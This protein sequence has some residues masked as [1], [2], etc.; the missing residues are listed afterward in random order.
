MEIRTDDSSPET[1]GR[2]VRL[3]ALKG[4]RTMTTWM[5]G[6][7]TLAAAA[8]IPACG[9]DGDS[10]V[11]NV[12]PVPT[13]GTIL[14]VGPNN[15]LIN[16]SPASADVIISAIG[17]KNLSGN[18]VALDY[19]PTTGALYGLGSAE[20]LYQIDPQTGECSAVGP[21]IVAMTGTDFGMDV[22]PT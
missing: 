5:R 21:L 8:L 14:Y 2:K 16:V 11:L 12:L 20:Q 22:D 18:I 3:G 1:G 17:L 13:T 15:V 10:F 4:D 6:V 7:L 9:S 19:H